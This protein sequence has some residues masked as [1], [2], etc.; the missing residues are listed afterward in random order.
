MNHRYISYSDSLEEKYGYRIYRVGVDAGFSCPNRHGQNREGGCVYCDSQGATAS[1]LRTAESSYASKSAFE[2]K[3]DLL[4]GNGNLKNI[5]EQIERGRNFL[6][7]R[8][9]AEHFALYFQ[10]YSNTFAPVEKLK[11][12]YDYSLGMYDWEQFII[13][14]RPDCID[15]EKI[16]LIESYKTKNRNVAVEL[17]LQSGDDKL[18]KAMNRGHDVACFLKAASLVKEHGIDLCVHV[19]SGFPG[20][21]KDELEKTIN[22]INSVHPYAIKIHNLNIT[23]GTKLFEDYTNGLAN[24]PCATRHIQSSIY[25]LRR[26]ACDIVI[27]R[28]ICES[29]SHRL[30]S[31]RVFPD[32]NN[33]IRMLDAEMER[34]DVRQGD[35]Y[36]FYCC[37]QS[38]SPK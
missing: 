38:F 11:K 1:Y 23:A 5:E 30:A 2:E 22:V 4:T 31:P 27:E 24:A 16:K 37:S 10:A 13:S 36:S 20:E 12:I 34:Q 8:Y 18:L 29:P 17:G 3:I 7:R 28:L 21:G 25:L 35:L 15:E 6:K 14:T 19:L 33:Y 9:K 32:K 26:I